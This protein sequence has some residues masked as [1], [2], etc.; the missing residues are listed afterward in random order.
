DHENG[1]AFVGPQQ[2]WAILGSSEHDWLVQIGISL[3]DGSYIPDKMMTCAVPKERLGLRPGAILTVRD[4]VSYSA[5]IHAML[6][7]LWSETS[8]FDKVCDYS[9]NLSP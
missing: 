4:A 2:L 7:S 9:Y 6:P 8:R 3:A 1:R 5:L